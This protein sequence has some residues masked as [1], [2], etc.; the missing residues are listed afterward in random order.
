LGI[1]IENK[2]N[3][4]DKQGKPKHRLEDLLK[5]KVR[6]L[7]TGAVDRRDGMRVA[8]IDNDLKHLIGLSI[9]GEDDVIVVK[10]SG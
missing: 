1:H 10:R 5:P 7:P 9:I 4:L 8:S 6:R 3:E 2:L